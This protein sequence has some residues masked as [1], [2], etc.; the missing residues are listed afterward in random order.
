M[1]KKTS[2][3]KNYAL[4]SSVLYLDYKIEE[5]LNNRYT[6]KQTIIYKNQIKAINDFKKNGTRI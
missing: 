3:I 5:D 6:C 1:N 4:S 2:L